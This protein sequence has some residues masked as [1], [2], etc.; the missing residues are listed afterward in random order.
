[1]V[2]IRRFWM[3]VIVIFRVERPFELAPNP[4]ATSVVP[5]LWFRFFKL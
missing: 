3:P 1:M 2:I 5:G 4:G